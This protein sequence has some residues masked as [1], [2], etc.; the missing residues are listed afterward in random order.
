MENKVL[1]EYWVLEF[2]I[3]NELNVFSWFYEEHKYC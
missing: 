1:T 2:Q 3:F